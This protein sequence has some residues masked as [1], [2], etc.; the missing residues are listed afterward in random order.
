MCI[1]KYLAPWSPP[2]KCSDI[3]AGPD[4]SCFGR[5]RFFL[6]GL[7]CEMA[8]S[9]TRSFGSG[10]SSSGHSGPPSPTSTTASTPER[11]GT[12][13]MGN[14]ALEWDNCPVIRSRLRDMS[15]FMKHV[16]EKGDL[17]DAFCEKTVANL[18]ANDAVLSP[19][20]K[21]MAAHDRTLPSLDKL[22][23]QIQI[24]FV[25]SK[26]TYNKHGDRIYQDAWAIRRLCSLGKAQFHRTTWP[27]DITFQTQTDITFQTQT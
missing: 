10:A 25:R 3:I 5:E 2:P 17:V 20:F 7:F 22:M 21:L 15:Y 23:E 13:D 26:A 14:L 8:P 12:W 18:R 1:I 11:V 19:V 24:L 27:K 4:R 9:K 6:C 16:N